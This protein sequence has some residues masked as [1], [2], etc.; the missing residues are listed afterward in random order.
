MKVSPSFSKTADLLSIKNWQY[1]SILSGNLSAICLLLGFVLSGNLP[2]T[3]PWWT[4]ERFEEHYHAHI[5]GTQAATIFLMLGGGFYLPYSAIIAKRMRLIPALDPIIPDLVL[6]C[7]ACGFAAFMLAATFM[8]VLTFRDYGAETI[9]LLNDLMWMAAFLPWPAFWVQMWTVSW[10]IFSDPG[11][12]TVFPTSM[13]WVNLVTPLGLAFA[14]GIHIQKEG[15][16]AWNGALSYWV[17]LAM[18]GIQVSYDCLVMM[19]T[20]REEGSF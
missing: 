16:M 3:K 15:P 5:K 8:S 17:G 9:R 6:A 12:K 18:Y 2:P 10:G 7:G 13:G 4:A 11:P 14:A 1:L 20:V 19:K